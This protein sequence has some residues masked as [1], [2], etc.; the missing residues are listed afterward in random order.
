MFMLTLLAGAEGK[1]VG[2][3]RTRVEFEAI[4]K[5]IRDFEVKCTAGG[6]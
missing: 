2:L 6:Q 5:Q 4:E 3:M 1:S